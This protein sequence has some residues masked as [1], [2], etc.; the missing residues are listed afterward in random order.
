MF[1]AEKRKNGMTEKRGGVR[2]GV[3]AR[4][5]HPAQGPDRVRTDWKKERIEDGMLDKV[6]RVSRHSSCLP[7]LPCFLSLS[8][9]PKGITLESVHE[10]C[11]EAY[12]NQSSLANAAKQSGPFSRALIQHARS[13]QGVA[14]LVNDVR[15]KA[16]VQHMLKS[17][18]SPST[19]SCSTESKKKISAVQPRRLPWAARREITVEKAWEPKTLACRACAAGRRRDLMNR[20]ASSERGALAATA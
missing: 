1:V 11:I 5:S 9:P 15:H 8:M 2:R 16:S 19:L 10:S 17:C 4:R 14:S 7:C 6:A 12:L 13:M 18:S 20:D 3:G